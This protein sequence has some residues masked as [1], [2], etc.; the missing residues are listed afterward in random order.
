MRIKF[1]DQKLHTDPKEQKAAGCFKKW[2]IKKHYR[3]SD[4][5]NPKCDGPRCA[6]KNTLGTLFM[7]KISAGHGD[8]DSIVAAKK[9]VDH[10]DLAHSPPMQVDEQIPNVFHGLLLLK[11]GWCYEAIILYSRT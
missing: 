9:D 4:E 10:D 3:E 11:I 2:Q 1:R 7:R 5:H 6:P 8:N